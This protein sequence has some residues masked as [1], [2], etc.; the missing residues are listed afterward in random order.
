MHVIKTSWKKTQD[1]TAE[2]KLNG[3]ELEPVT[4]S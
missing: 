2:Q 3:Y 4:L 1:Y